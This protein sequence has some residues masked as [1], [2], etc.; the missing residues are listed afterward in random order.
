MTPV[1]VFSNDM[2]LS[3]FGEFRDQRNNVKK[4]H[5]QSIVTETTTYTL[6]AANPWPAYRPA[7]GQPPEG[8]IVMTQARM[9]KGIHAVPKVSPGPAMP[10]PSTP[11]GPGPPPK[12]KNARWG[13]G[14]PPPNRA[15]RGL[16]GVPRPQVKRPAA[17][18][19]PIGYPFPYWPVMTP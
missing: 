14:R 13:G 2:N 3:S 6:R 17:I 16:L 5:Y 11:C 7:G 12:P 10:Y 1:R 19:F 9:G 15:S 4:Y 8:R 18:F